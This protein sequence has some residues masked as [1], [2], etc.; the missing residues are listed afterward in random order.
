MNFLGSIFSR[1]GSFLS[2]AIR[3][4]GDIAGSIARKVGQSGIIK[5]IGDSGIIQKVA[6]IAAEK[7]GQMIQDKMQ[8]KPVPEPQPAEVQTVAAARKGYNNCHCR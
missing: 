2:P 3:K 5:K 4:V 1:L 6:P 8:P 7:V